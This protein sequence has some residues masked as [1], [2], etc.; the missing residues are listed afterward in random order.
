MDREVKSVKIEADVDDH[1]FI[2]VECPSRPTIS[3]DI[4]NWHGRR[5]LGV[6]VNGEGMFSGV[7]DARWLEPDG[8]GD[9]IRYC[10]ECGE[11]IKLFS[12]QGHICPESQEGLL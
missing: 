4:G 8:K 5:S 3:I 6:R 2:M 10:P 11:K 7:V 9:P 12:S 1:V